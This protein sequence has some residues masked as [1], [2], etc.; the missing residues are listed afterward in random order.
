[1]RSRVHAAGV[2]HIMHLLMSNGLIHAG[3]L[4]DVMVLAC[5]LAGGCISA[6]DHCVIVSFANMLL[7]SASMQSLVT[8]SYAV[9][10]GSSPMST[11]FRINMQ[12]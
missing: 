3:I 4:Q 5:Y 11:S 10:F 6:S 9:L 12:H 1:M 2:L 8:A 7:V